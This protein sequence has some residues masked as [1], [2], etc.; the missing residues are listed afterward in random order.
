[1]ATID[2]D[3]LVIGAGAAG[4]AFTD[5]LIADSDA[6]VVMVDRRHGPAGHWND[7]YPFV[8]LHQ[9]STYYG[10]N[11]RSLGNDSI[12]ETGLNAGF[13]ERAT[14]PQI[15]DYFQRVMEERFLSSGQVRFVG[16]SDYLGL[17]SGECAFESRLTGAVTDVR[18]RRKVVD[19]R[20]LEPTVPS[21]HTPSFEVD[22]D[23]RLLT[24]NQLASL[25]ETPSGYTIIG[26]GK[27]GM[28]ACTWLLEG[29]VDPDRICW[30][31]P[32]D[33]WVLD[34][35][36]FQPLDQVTA[37]IDGFSLAVEAGAEAGSVDELFERLESSGQIVRLD[38]TVKPTMYHA[39]TLAPAEIEQLRSIENVVRQGH[40]RR[41][42]VDEITLEQGTI[43]T[44]RRRVHVD[45]SAAGLSKSPARPIFE[46]DRI[47]LQP[48][49]TAVPPFNAAFAGY[50][51]ATREHD[52]EKLS[53]CPVNRYPETDVDWIPNMYITLESLGRW[54]EQGD[55]GEWLERSRLNISRGMFD[56]AAEPRMND[57]IGRLIT[58]TDPA[59]ENLKRLHAT[60]A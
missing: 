30:I 15:V 52:E 25:A 34:R 35:A 18:V 56:H 1:M 29:G 23:A 5:A 36:Y 3:Y 51:E 21:T 59:I 6:E 47:T 13:Y 41:I 40:V 32:R 31:R 45:C 46:P 2:T 10:V 48:I 19:A 11:S 33:P 12:D 42:G 14:A 58:N 49:R 39:G 60:V 43:P 37:L 27:T 53:L 22:A 54:N 8:R 55:V 16:M 7:A 9:T 57:A 24:V 38:R 4:M 17:E 20:Y 50:V 44:D 26:G 28:D